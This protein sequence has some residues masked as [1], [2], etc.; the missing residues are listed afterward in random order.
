[1]A[2]DGSPG[3]LPHAAWEINHKRVLRVM[4]EEA[5]LCQLERRF[6]RTTGSGHALRTLPNLLADPAPARPVH[7]WVADITCI[8]LPTTFAHPARVFDA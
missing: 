7:V 5:L 6:V 2:P 1:M 8:R 3:A 4:R